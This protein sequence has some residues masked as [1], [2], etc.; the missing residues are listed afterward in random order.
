[1]KRRNNVPCTPHNWSEESFEP[2]VWICCF[3]ASYLFSIKLRKP[4]SHCWFVACRWNHGSRGSPVAHECERTFSV[5]LWELSRCDGWAALL[6]TF[7]VRNTY[8]A[9]FHHLVVMCSAL[10][11]LSLLWSFV[12]V[13]RCKSA[14]LLISIYEH[15]HRITEKRKLTR[16]SQL[17]QG[18]FASCY[19]CW[20]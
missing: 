9:L 20:A 3:T 1:M 10:S 8:H 18:H 6:E 7:S 17:F 11:E 13:A 19:F 12:G 2:M 14:M 5:C 15:M 16:L 4:Q